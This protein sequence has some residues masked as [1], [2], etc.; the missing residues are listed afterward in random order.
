[1]WRFRRRPR[2][3]SDPVWDFVRVDKVTVTGSAFWRFQQR[4]IFSL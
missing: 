4:L 3:S 1:M 2:S